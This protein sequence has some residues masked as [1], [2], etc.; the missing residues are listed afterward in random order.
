MKKN[1]LI[2]I[3]LLTAY[4]IPFAFLAVNGDAVSGT[5]LFY[6]VMIAGF[7]LL[8]RGALKTK[9][10][11]VLWLGS[12][13]SAVSSCAAAKLTGLEAMGYYFKPF[14][15]YSLIAV[16][17]AVVFIVHAVIALMHRAKK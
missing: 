3:L 13:L 1:R 4:C 14:T 10:A 17:S 7:S 2:R 9:N 16:I 8:C 5:M 15:S 12:I 11:S 6:G